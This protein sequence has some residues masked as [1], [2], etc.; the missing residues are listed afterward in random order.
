M[1]DAVVFAKGVL[2][3]TAGAV[4]LVL[5]IYRF[6][7]YSRTVFVID[8]ALLM[9]LLSATRASF[10]LVGEFI[11]RQQ[12]S[13]RRCIIYGVGSVSVATI[14]E[15]FGANTPLKIVGFIDD[16]PLQDRSRVSG[17]PILGGFDALVSLVRNA[18]ADCV[19]LN[20]P[21]VDVDCLLQLEIA[22][23]DHDVEL[24]RLDIR[25]KPLSAVS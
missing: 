10:R 11:H 13:G 12:S 18:G 4:L 17:Y 5:F 20:A 23:R 25:L 7:S 1:M 16:N 14:R 15:A 21:L 9:L 24:L 6:E 22:C 2:L 19:L 3:G 8:A